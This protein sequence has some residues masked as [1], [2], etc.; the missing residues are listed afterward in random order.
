MSDTVVNS[1]LRLRYSTTIQVGAEGAH[2]VK[3]A[4]LLSAAIIGPVDVFAQRRP[5]TWRLDEFL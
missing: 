2:L 4:L 3:K 1:R 5:G